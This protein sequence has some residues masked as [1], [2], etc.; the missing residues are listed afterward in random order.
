MNKIPLP[1]AEPATKWIVFVYWH[2]SHL[3]N[4]SLAVLHPAKLRHRAYLIIEEV[5]G[6]NG[7][8][9][10]QGRCM[11][12]HKGCLGEKPQ[13]KSDWHG[14]AMTTWDRLTKMTQVYRVCFSW[15]GSDGAP[16]QL[17][18]YTLRPGNLFVAWHG[19]RPWSIL[20]RHRELEAQPGFRH[21][22]DGLSLNQDLAE[23]SAL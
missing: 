12:I 17:D 21:W 19:A 2:I 6:P 15:A 10:G 7:E 3:Y 8:P 13:M 1:P 11:F 9:T 23:L 16:R 14:W 18:L 4:E 20:E 22:V 5:V